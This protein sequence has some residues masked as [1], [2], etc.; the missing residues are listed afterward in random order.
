MKIYFDPVSTA[1]REESARELAA[2]V[3]ASPSE[4][5]CITTV[6]IG[7]PYPCILALT[8][9]DTFRACT[10]TVAALCC[11]LLD[12]IPYSRHSKSPEGAGVLHKPCNLC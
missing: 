6:R 5:D 11:S 2:R 1:A 10:L 4:K 8:Y 12:G 9:C 7:I 3:L